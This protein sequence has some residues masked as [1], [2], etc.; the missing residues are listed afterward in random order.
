MFVKSV[1]FTRRVHSYQNMSPLLD[2]C[3]RG[4]SWFTVGEQWLLFCV[5]C[6]NSLCVV[7]YD[8]G[9][10]A[11][12]A[13]FLTK[14]TKFAEQKIIQDFIKRI[15]RDILVNIGVFFVYLT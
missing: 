9:T 1:C 2:Q 12:H 5:V 3:Y 10:K 11:I 4:V 14:K 15:P 8:Q 13:L 7:K 6:L